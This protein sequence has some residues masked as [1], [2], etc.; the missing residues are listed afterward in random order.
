MVQALSAQSHRA[1]FATAAL[2]LA[3]ITATSIV[4]SAQA[5]PIRLVSTPW[6]P[7]TNAAGQPR[8]ALDLVEAALGR[9]GVTSTTTIVPAA[10]FTPALL[11]NTYDGS[12]AAWKDAARETLL[13]FSE[14]YMENRLVLV[15]RKGADVSATTL[16]ALKGKRVAIVEGYSYGQIESAGPVFVRATGEEDSLT[17]VLHGDADYV[18]MDE[19]VVTYLINNYPVES[20]TKIEIGKAP[21]ISRPLHLAIRRSRP[22]ADGII[23]RFNAQLKNMILDHTYHKLLH[24]DWIWAAVG[25]AGQAAFIP[26]SDNAGQKPPDRAYTVLSPPKTDTVTTNKGFYIGGTIYQDW[27]SVPNKFKIEDPKYPDYRKSTGS[28][29]KFVW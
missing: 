15:G 7:F 1:R 4:L 17:K 3:S 2:L 23:R 13:V 12:A 19:L 24:V 6:S 27:A 26:A 9:I 16:A 14:P 21:L 18:L 11:G 28:L 10:E 29:F 22:D 25:E 8:F 20:R 5:A